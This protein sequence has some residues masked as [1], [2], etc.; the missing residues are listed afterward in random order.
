MKNN[1]H[2]VLGML[3]ALLFLSGCSEESA[4]NFLKKI[5]KAPP[6]SIERDV[7]GH[8]QIYS[9]QLILRLARKSDYKLGNRD[10][11]Y[12]AFEGGSKPTPIP[13]VQ[14]IAL[15]KDEN[16]NITVTSDRKVFDVVKSD[17]FCYGLELKYYD[18]NGMLINHQFS[19]YYS[20]DEDNSTLLVHQHFFTIQ[21]YSLNGRQ[22]V[23]PMSLD[24]VYYSKY[25][26]AENAN[27]KRIAASRISPSNIYAPD[28]DN[29]VD[30]VRYSLGLAEKSIENSMKPSATEPYDDPVTGKRYRLYQTIN[31]FKLNERV[32]EVFSYEYRD[33]DP[34]EEELGK[35]LTDYDDMNRLRA[36][37]TVIRL[38]E[39]RS[40][41]DGAPYDA[42][43]FKGMLYFKKA[44]ITFQMRVC[45]C[46]IL[47]RV[48]IPAN[49]NQ[50]GK[51]G[52]TG[53]NVSG[54]VYGY[55]MLQ[56]AWNSFDIDYPIAFRVIAD[57]DGDKEKC[58][59]DVQRFYP[60]A[61][62]TDMQAMFWGGDSFFNR[63]PKI[64]M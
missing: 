47:N 59:G 31:N 53:N 7:K 39:K 20:D 4:D 28:D 6:S 43:G 21:N 16:G 37:S 17:K 51:Y 8:E 44:H 46:H 55:N 49:E 1:I 56:T 32:P 62:K 58:M 23:Y 61:E 30:S 57:L 40:L 54:G 10:E 36:G 3:C 19:N 45:I 12:V 63:I 5:V 18:V 50:L 60:K 22:L 33:T 2:I 24:S 38:R 27:G 14:E 35:D 42:L 34:V 41:D 15:S 64:T 52:Y 29:Q 25:A 48:S 11:T 9:V 26:F 13:L